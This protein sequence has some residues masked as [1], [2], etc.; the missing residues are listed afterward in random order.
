MKFL[1]ETSSV[2]GSGGV[3]VAGATL[4][5]PLWWGIFSTLPWTFAKDQRL[6]NETELERQGVRQ[7]KSHGHLPC[8][9]KI[10]IP[11]KQWICKQNQWCYDVGDSPTPHSQR[12]EAR[13][14]GM[15]EVALQAANSAYVGE[16]GSMDQWHF[17]VHK[18][19]VINELISIEKGTCPI[20][21]GLIFFLSFNI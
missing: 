20:Y 9:K 18:R 19:W 8:L 6:L 16:D 21:K 4:K 17:A 14:K 15:V 10:C 7:A 12:Q 3:Q 13:E 11:T 1:S 5:S 2:G